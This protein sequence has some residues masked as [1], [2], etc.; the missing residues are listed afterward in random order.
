MPHRRKHATQPHLLKRNIDTLESSLAFYKKPL[1][2]DAIENK[3]KLVAPAF[4]MD[5]THV[6]Q[7]IQKLK[8]RFLPE[9]L[10]P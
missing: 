10:I 9:Y 8:V 7:A 5:D 3:A 2:T 6:E 1:T 4:E